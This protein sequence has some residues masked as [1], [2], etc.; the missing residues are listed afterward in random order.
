MAVHEFDGRKGN[1]GARK[2]GSGYQP[3][4]GRKP[5]AGKRI[6]KFLNARF[7]RMDAEAQA[8]YAKRNDTTVEAAIREDIANYGY[9]L[10][11]MYKHLDTLTEGTEEYN[12]QLEAITRI[13][14]C[15][16]RALL[17]LQDALLNPTATQGE[18][19]QEEIERELEE[20]EKEVST[21]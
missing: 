3:N 15:K 7:Y 10:D 8:I 17:A 12:K 18:T 21:D 14:K 5:E 2:G 19:E 4:A 11:V 20:Y 16:Q 13:E 6:G 9:Q 1:G